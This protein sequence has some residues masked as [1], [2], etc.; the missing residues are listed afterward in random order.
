MERRAIWFLPAIGVA[1]SILALSTV[2]SVPI[3]VE[4]VN[5]LDKW[6][7]TFAYCVLSLSFLIAFK[8][9]K[10][11]NRKSLRF[12]LIAASVYGVLLEYVQYTFFSNRYFEWMD[13]IA[14]VV[15]VVTGWILFKL[16]TGGKK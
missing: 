11:L 1:L 3:Q 14:N 2:L 4:G 12:I 10:L 5:H 6:Q 8:K 15:G 9:T 13:A 7:H 16:F